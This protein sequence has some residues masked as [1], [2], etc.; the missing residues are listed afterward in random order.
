MTWL[1]SAKIKRNV[2]CVSLKC[3]RVVEALSSLILKWGLTNIGRYNEKI[4]NT[5]LIDAFEGDKE[6]VSP[7]CDTK[8]CENIT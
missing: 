1:L 7:Y 3:E 6:K 4:Q 2:N 5:T 8:N